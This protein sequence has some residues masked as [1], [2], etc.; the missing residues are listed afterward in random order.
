MNEVRSL[1]SIWTL[2]LALALAGCG[3]G[4]GGGGGGNTGPVYTPALQGTPTG[5]LA[6]Q[7]IDA[8][9]GSV[10][11]ADSRVTLSIPA[12]AL[13]TPTDITIQ[14][15]TNTGPNGDG[16]AY[17]L[18]PEGTTFATPITLTLHL[19][20]AEVLALDT[21]FVATQHADGLWY[22]LPGQ[23]RDATAK[24][25]SIPTVHFSDYTALETLQ[26]EPS[27]TRVRTG[28]TADFQPSLICNGTPG[29]DCD[30]DL[31][32]PP[33]GSSGVAV[34][35]ATPLTPLTFPSIDSMGP[36]YWSVNG[37]MH[38][39]SVHGTIDYGRPQYTDFSGHYTAPSAKPTPSNVTV[40]LTFQLTTGQKIIGYA[41]VDV[42]DQERWTGTSTIDF[43]DGTSL[44]ANWTFV[45]VGDPVNNVYTLDVEGGN[46]NF[47]PLTMQNGCPLTVS[48]LSHV[49]SPGEGSLT[50]DYN[51][52]TDPKSPMVS[53]G[54]ATVWPATYTTHCPPQDVPI[55]GS[56]NGEW[57]PNFGPPTP[58]QAVNG[59]V[60]IPIST[61][62][63]TGVVHL[64]KQ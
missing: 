9:G 58:V 52:A 40:T 49:I 28:F 57:W 43:I 26:I 16:L 32:A 39:D 14:P 13:S 56:I 6:T 34:P 5:T 44:T 18:G 10:I 46:V 27:L 3:G 24:T 53:G 7:T 29:T 59:G 21:S 63:A 30:S 47:T 61:P 51:L 41:Q 8:N 31:L 64:G 38:G 54:G 22:S 62:L 42:Y 11:S 33:P 2:M 35:N 23:T 37:A 20:D 19:S 50:V 17:R 60:D 36:W 48:P 4:G 25:L 15:I 1:K 55:P 45:Q 12:G